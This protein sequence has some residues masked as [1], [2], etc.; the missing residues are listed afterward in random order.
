MNRL[1]DRLI[2]RRAGVRRTP[3]P[4]ITAEEVE[5]AQAF[6]PRSKFFV[7]GHARSGTTLLM[8][9]IDVHPEVHCSR[10]AHFFTRPPLLESLVGDPAVAEWLNRGSVRWNRGRDLSPV[11]LRAAADFILEREARRRGARIVGDKS[12]N[13]LSHGE[14]VQRMQRI[15]PDARLIFIVR[16]GRDAVLS[17]RFQSFIDATQ[18]LDPQ[19]WKIR[20]AF[21]SDPDDFGEGRRSLFTEKGLRLEAL[22]WLKNVTTTSAAGRELFAGRF[23]EIRYEDLV[24]DP[25]AELK[26]IWAFLATEQDPADLAER[27][28]AVVDVNR[29]AD[30]QAEKA[31]GLAEAIPKGQRGNWRLFFTAGDKAIF[32]QCAGE[33]LA[34][35]GYE[36]DGNW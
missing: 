30:W 36:N 17:H 13:N 18:H 22:S 35:L 26:K 16:D 31:G 20:A 8:R 2:P 21:Q 5:E 28:Q 19:D 27:V 25:L 6:F 14:A 12:P 29:D 7:F 11:V 32:K 10:Q 33:L 1:I 9:L 34:H 23:H 15:Y 24:D 4:A 3:I